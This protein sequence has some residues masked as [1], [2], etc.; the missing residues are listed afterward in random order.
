MVLIGWLMWRLKRM[1]VGR[2]LM[3]CGVSSAL[4][5]CVYGSVFGFEHL[6]DPM[7][8][9]MGFAQ[10]PVDVLSLIHI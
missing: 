8:R 3:R 6:L 9:A 5:G 4:F 2:V 1:E 10:K 7:Y